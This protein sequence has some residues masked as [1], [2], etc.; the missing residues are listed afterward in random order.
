[1]SAKPAA[2][3]RVARP[4]P[5]ALAVFAAE[6]RPD[7]DAVKFD[8]AIGRAR[9]KEWT[10]D[11]LLAEVFRLIREPDSTVDDLLAVMDDP[12]K[13]PA[14]R[15]DWQAGAAYARQLLDNR[16]GARAATEGDRP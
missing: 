15:G 12:R 3:R 1:M 5:A 9:A 14:T 11:R 13:Q 4:N 8:G 2:P 16:P 10:W 7:W 6:M